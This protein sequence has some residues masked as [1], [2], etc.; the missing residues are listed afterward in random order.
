MEAPPFLK[1]II[2]SLPPEIQPF[3][4]AGG[5]LIPFVLITLLVFLFAIS[6]FRRMLARKGPRTREP[7]LTEDLGSYPLAPALWGT[8]R[9]TVHGL[10]VRIRL[11]VA[12]PLGH[13]GGYVGAEQIEQFL[14]FVVPGLGAFIHADR[15]R[16]RV[17]PTQL[18]YQGFAAAF[19]RNAVR[20]DSEKQIS[21]WVLLMGKGLIN[22]RPVAIGFA[23]LA[24]QD[25]TLGRVVL[26]HPHDWMQVVRIVG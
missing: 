22:R 21:R 23:L 4:D 5:W 15:P 7:D 20:P 6:S 11:V 3:V 24:D 18:S 10:P 19:R 8:R 2:Q 26:E 25:N 14:D 17:W 9:L 1:P 16:V 12:A 13:E